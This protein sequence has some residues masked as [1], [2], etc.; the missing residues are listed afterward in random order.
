MVY[1]SN[2]E[3]TGGYTGGASLVAIYTYGCKVWPDT[4]VWSGPNIGPETHPGDYYIRWTPTSATGSFSIGGR[5]Y[6]LEDYNGYF[7]DFTGVI[8]AGA[9]SQ[10]SLSTIETNAYVIENNAFYG[11]L[12]DSISLSN[13]VYIGKDAFR[14]NTI[15]YASMPKCEH[16]GSGAFWNGVNSTGMDTMILGLAYLNSSVIEDNKIKELYVPTQYKAYYCK[17][18]WSDKMYYYPDT[19]TDHIH[20]YYYVYYPGY[21]NTYCRSGISTYFSDS[22]ISYFE[23]NITGFNT[24]CWSGYHSLKSCSMP[25]C[26]TIGSG[27]FTNCDSLEYI[28]APKAFNVYTS[29]FDGCVSLKS[30]TFASM[31]VISSLFISNIGIFAISQNA[32]RNCTNLSMIKIGE[33]SGSFIHPLESANAFDGCTSLQKI[34]VPSAQLSYYLSASQWSNYSNIIIGY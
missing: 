10:L 33:T 28:N 15:R 17:S 14:V 2:S 26:V 1:Q 21:Y 7:T 4:D 5:T 23:T 13:C 16:I 32:F 12:L 25:Y 34:Y 22:A 27:A 31:S 6:R 8:T 18:P 9:F 24:G 30:F 3:I 19:Y 11:C 29:A 20:G